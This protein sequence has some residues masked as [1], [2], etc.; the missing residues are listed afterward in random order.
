MAAIP[1]SED[2]TTLFENGMLPSEMARRFGLEDRAEV[3]AAEARCV[4]LHNS[5]TLDLLWLIEG[6]GLQALS[7]SIFFMATDFFCRILPELEALPGRM[8][9]CVVALVNHGGTDGVANQPNAALRAWCAKDPRRA[10][11][12]IAAARSG[13]DLASR[14][15]TFALEAIN[16]ITEARDIALATDGVRRLSAIT[17]LGRTADDDPTSRTETFATFGTLL[18]LGADDALRAS[19]LHAAVAI[20]AHSRDVP[21]P[22]VL[23]LVQRLLEDAGEF[24][25]HQSAYVLWAYREALNSEIVAALLQALAHLNPANKGTVNELD[26]GLQSLLE[27]RHDEAAIDYVTELLSRPDN[28]LELK[29]LDSFTGTLLSGPPDRLSRVAV[30][31][32]LLG[33][34]RLCGGL[35]KAIQG[36]GLDGAPL[37]LRSDDLAISPAAQVFI[38]RKAIGWFFLKSTTAASVLVSVLR[39]CDIETTLEVQK[40][41]V[42]ALLMNY[43]SVRDYLE[44]LSP[45]DVAKGRVDQAL[46]QNEAYLTAMRTVPSIKE[47]APSERNR[48]IERVRMSDQMRDVHKQ[49]QSRSVLLSLV[50][51]SVL[52]Y[53]NRSLSFIK[54]SK[55]EL[56]PMEMDLQ[57][58]GVSFEMPRM[59]IVDPVGLD[60]NLRI[61][62]AERMVQ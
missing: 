31:W 61:F 60:F 25:V 16:N 36:P 55:N 47:L 62:R 3:Q 7:G 52:L 54:N 14:H 18:D 41:L 8:M 57:P 44:G 21:S 58:H 50:R 40:L 49:A 2:L 4:V 39:V 20:L 12:V 45:D 5:G 56:Q 23:L 32:L 15:L 24:T 46:A 17:A 1:T 22:E 33:A 30:R 29:D 27:F 42:E 13:D 37:D 48:R 19:M 9:A 43:G 59:E 10:R 53:G 51:R 34:P 26:L 6:G 35:A 38:C 11:E 28:S